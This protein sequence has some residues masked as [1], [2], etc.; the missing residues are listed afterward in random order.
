MTQAAEVPFLDAAARS[1]LLP[2][3]TL[4]AVAAA[5][6]WD[7]LLSGAAFPHSVQSFAYGEAKAGRGWRVV[8]L[9]VRHAGRPVAVV[10]ALER[11]FAGF[12][13]ATRINRGPVFLAAHP[14]RDLVVAVYRAIRQ[15]WGRLPHGVLLIAPA[16]AESEDDHAI[17]TEAG[18]RRRRGNGWGSARI[19]LR[20]DIETVFAGLDGKWRNRVRSG[21]R[22]GVTVRVTRDAADFA[23]MEER[24]LENMQA[25][26]FSGHDRGFLAALRHSFGDDLVLVQAIHEQRPVAGLVLIRV[27]PLADGVVAWF[28]PEARELKAGNVVAW[29]AIEEM[30]RLGCTSYDVGGTNSDKGFSTF[31]AG[32]KGKDYLLLGEYVSV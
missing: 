10:Q 32:M 16:L 24:H 15:R 30:H 1:G 21:Q 31:K 7:A 5:S 26:A 12:R 9:L 20:P 28:G 2:Q 18:Y 3:V 11:H 29:G 27:G 19:D 22:N 17:M 8:R 14:V 23:W 6:Q 13:V 4:E 25:K